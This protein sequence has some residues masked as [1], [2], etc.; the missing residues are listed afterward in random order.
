VEGEAISFDEVFMTATTPATSQQAANDASVTPPLAA[1]DA[2]ATVDA[3]R[4]AMPAPEAKLT[5]EQAAVVPPESKVKLPAPAPTTHLVGSPMAEVANDELAT[6]V[7]EAEAKAAVEI[8]NR[9]AE[10]NSAG[11]QINTAGLA[12]DLKITRNDIVAAATG[13]VCAPNCAHCSAQKEAAPP[14]AAPAVAAA[15]PAAAPLVEQPVAENKPEI[16][17]IAP[18]VTQVA[19]PATVI[20]NPAIAAGRVVANEAHAKGAA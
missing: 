5:A 13:H 17:S 19:T 15:A 8:G 18:A 12:V 3:S 14:A 6:I 9:I 1:N 11:A 7:K 10:L 4:P 2:S 20:D 16:Q